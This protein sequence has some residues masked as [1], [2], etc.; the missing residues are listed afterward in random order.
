MALAL[1]RGQGDRRNEAIILNSLGVS[2]TRLGRPDEARTVLEE[3]LTLSRHL[4][5][6]ELEAHALASLGQV[7]LSAHDL[8]GAAEYFERSRAVRH[9]IGDRV[10]EGWMHLRLAGLR[11]RIGDRAGALDA[12]AAAAAAAA[13]T[14]DGALLAACAEGVRETSD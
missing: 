7:S 9:T 3:S 4:G 1:I 8:S 14:N 11:H 10:G 6:E 2:L 13:E 12:Q 5:E